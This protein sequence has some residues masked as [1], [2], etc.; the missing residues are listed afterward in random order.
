MSKSS[1][2]YDERKMIAQIT[3]T[4]MEILI[5]NAIVLN[6]VVYDSQAE[7]G[8]FTD[9]LIGLIDSVML[10]NLGVRPDV[11]YFEEKTPASYISEEFQEALK[12]VD[13]DHCKH[14]LDEYLVLAVNTKSQKAMLGS[15]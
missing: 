7:A 4:P 2:E 6:I 3:M 12:K 15:Y 13:H 5:D 9:R 11:F 14:D 8:E 10:S 1:R